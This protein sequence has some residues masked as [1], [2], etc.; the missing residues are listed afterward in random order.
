MS[1]AV[2]IVS[3]G[4]ELLIGKIANTNAQWLAH[5]LASLGI[6][7]VRITVVGDRVEEISQA[8]REAFGRAS[9]FV[10]VTGGLG[11]T[12]DDR[13]LEGLSDAVDAPLRKNRQALKMVSERVR[14]AS[15]RKKCRLGRA[16][17]KMALMPRGSKPVPNPVG[18]APG[19]RI[20]VRGVELI[21]LP[22]V[23][24]EMKAIFDESIAP[25]FRRLSG[26]RRLYESSLRVSGIGE[27]EIAP[28][29]DEVSRDSPHVYVKSHP[30]LDE[31]SIWIEL[32]LSTMAESDA[33]GGSRI[34]RVE[35]R[36]RSLIEENGG[37]V[38]K[39]PRQLDDV[40]A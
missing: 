27:P 24:Q 7:V 25:D 16:Y 13:T 12:F 40:R 22:G 8:L 34:S 29:I 31:R 11:P 18:L 1:C 6:S 36:I 10:V 19:V 33:E 5:R 20:R 32:H 26:G 14:A 23:P 4:N 35:D 28:M 17:E 38:E 39:M 2:E 3:V 9:R 30:K 15:G 37:L 21:C